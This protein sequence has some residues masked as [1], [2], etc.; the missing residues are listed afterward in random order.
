MVQCFG[1]TAT[2]LNG[3]FRANTATNRPQIDRVIAVIGHDSITNSAGEG[4]QGGNGSNDCSREVH[5]GK[6]IIFQGQIV[7]YDCFGENIFSRVGF[8]LP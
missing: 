7:N 1:I 3:F 5:V 2:C 8:E 4:C 6:D